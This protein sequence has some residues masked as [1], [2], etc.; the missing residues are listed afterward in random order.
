MI[1]GV[2][3]EIAEGERRV[4]LVPDAVKTLVGLGLAVVVE[5]GAGSAAGF[6][7]AAYEAAGARLESDRKLVWGTDL[8]TK[9]QAP[10]A[11]GEGH[12]VDDLR[13]DAV[14]VGFLRP[15]DEPELAQRLAEAGVTAFSMELMPRITRAQS[16]DALSSMS[17]IAGYRA[18][19]LAAGSLP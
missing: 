4:S 15:L 19:I 14:L 3:A 11:R 9:V 1:V 8:V 17:T 5:A 10:R 2:P 6:E 18:V 13:R 16:M 7:D 12:E